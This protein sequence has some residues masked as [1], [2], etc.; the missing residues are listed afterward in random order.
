VCALVCYFAG[1]AHGGARFYIAIYVLL[2]G[3]LLCAIHALPIWKSRVQAAGKEP[4]SPNTITAGA[5]LSVVGGLGVLFEVIHLPAVPVSAVLIL[6]FALLQLLVAVAAFLLDSGL[7]VL[8]PPREAGRPP[9]PS[10]PPSGAGP[11]S[12]QWEGSPR[13][14]PAGDTAGAQMTRPSMAWPSSEALGAPDVSEHPD[15]GRGSGTAEPEHGHAES[16]RRAGP[17]AY[18]P[19]TPESPPHGY[20][21]AAGPPP[22]QP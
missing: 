19:T 13:S 7:L 3:G 9:P 16:G 22:R 2:A 21:T 5:V 17:T 14:G 20:G 15:R 12:S 4:S 8:P 11:P 18:L 6:I 10:T 1:Y